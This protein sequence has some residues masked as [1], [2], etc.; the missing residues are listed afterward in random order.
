MGTQ[1]DVPASAQRGDVDGT[2][3][4][5]VISYSLYSD[6]QLI[7]ERDR[8]RDQLNELTVHPSSSA[9]VSQL[10]VSIDREIEGIANELMRRARSRHPSSRSLSSRLRFRLMSRPPQTG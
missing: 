4:D 7:S 1:P 8:L 3:V 5:G 9:A 10:L 2:K 6:E